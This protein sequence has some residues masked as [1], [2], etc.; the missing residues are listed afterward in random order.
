M[1]NSLAHKLDEETAERLQHMKQ[2]EHLHAVNWEL[3]QVVAA[4]H[5]PTHTRP[6]PTHPVPTHP[7]TL[8]SH[9]PTHLPSP[10][11]H[12]PPHPTCQAHLQAPAA[13]LPIRGSAVEAAWHEAI[14]IE[15]QSYQTQFERGELDPD[16]Y[17]RLETLLAELQAGASAS[18]EEQLEIAYVT[19]MDGIVQARGRGRV[20][21][22][23]GLG[24]CLGLG[25][26]SGLG[27][28]VYCLVAGLQLGQQGL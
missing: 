3:V 9:P 6:A 10:P 2:S 12:P 16:A 8:H 1:L 18:G 21:V 13:P 20:R 26:G 24:L 19:A 23:S 5:P 4:A 7:P 17:S 22:E 14:S 28:G 15:R 27:L 25:L 11:T